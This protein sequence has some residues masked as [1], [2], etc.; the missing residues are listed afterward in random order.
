[1]RILSVRE[2]TE[3]HQN[4]LPL[5]KLPKKLRKKEKYGSVHIKKSGI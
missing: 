2:A 4:Y 1:M 5:K 3:S